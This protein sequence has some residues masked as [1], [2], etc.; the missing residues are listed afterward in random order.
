MNIALGANNKRYCSTTTR[1]S[2]THQICLPPTLGVL[3]CSSSSY[4]LMNKRDDNSHEMESHDDKN[5]N[6]TDDDLNNFGPDQTWDP[7]DASIESSTGS[8][9]SLSSSLHNSFQIETSHKNV[10]Q[11]Y[12]F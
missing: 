1:R 9:S 8:Q 4:S 3:N 12:F 2:P 10:C 6:D 7:D 5:D 11:P